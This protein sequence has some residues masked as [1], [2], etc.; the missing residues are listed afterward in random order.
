VPG[1]IVFDNF[2]T[3]AW[4]PSP[5][6]YMYANTFTQNATAGSL[7][8]DGSGVAPGGA[9]NTIGESVTFTAASGLAEISLKSEYGSTGY[10]API[11]VTAA[12]GVGTM[13]LQMLVYSSSAVSL[14]FYLKDAQG[15]P[16]QSQYVGPTVT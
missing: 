15:S 3:T 13:E 12:G 8:F 14:Q 1:T 16:V 6:A 9:T 11:A 10:G 4:D 5:A 7:N 2:K